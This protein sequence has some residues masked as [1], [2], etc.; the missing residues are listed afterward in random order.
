MNIYTTYN[1]I[2]EALRIL[3]D[4]RQDEQPYMKVWETKTNCI[5]GTGTQLHGG[6]R[7]FALIHT[8]SLEGKSVFHL[9]AQNGDCKGLYVQVE[10]IKKLQ[11]SW[12]NGEPVELTNK[13]L[14]G[15]KKT[16]AEEISN[17]VD[18]KIIAKPKK[19]LNKN[20]EKP[21]KKIE[22]KFK[23]KEVKKKASLFIRKI[24]IESEAPNKRGLKKPEVPVF[25]PLHR[26]INF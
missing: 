17:S 4:I 21:N 19:K 13:I 11:I 12:R 20:G 24:D 1:E 14:L 16:E 7:L 10:K 26:K 23:N 9:Q 8:S 6:M 18:K 2:L 3:E 5:T 15:F 22:I 25:A